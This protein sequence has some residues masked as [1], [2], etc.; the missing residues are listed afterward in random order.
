MTDIHV[1]FDASQ[2]SRLIAV[3]GPPDIGDELR[4]R[5]IVTGIVRSS[6]ETTGYKT[7]TEVLEDVPQ[8]TF[9][10]ADAERSA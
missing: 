6:V 3:D 1:N 10:I 9:T 8:V 7:G 4:C 5:L 2:L